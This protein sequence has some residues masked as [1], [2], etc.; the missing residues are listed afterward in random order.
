[1]KKGGKWNGQVNDEVS[2]AFED[3]E[4]FDLDNSDDLNRFINK[5]EEILTANKEKTGHQTGPHKGH[6]GE[7]ALRALSQP[8]NT[9][10]YNSA[11]AY[12]KPEPTG[13]GEDNMVED[14]I[15]NLVDEELSR[16]DNSELSGDDDRDG[17]DAF[18]IKPRRDAE[19]AGYST[20]SAGPFGKAK[21]EGGLMNV[22]ISTTSNKA[23]VANGTQKKYQAYIGSHRSSLDDKASEGSLSSSQGSN[24]SNGGESQM[25]KELFSTT[26]KQINKDRGIAGMISGGGISSG[27]G[28]IDAD[29]QLI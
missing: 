14:E 18:E 26:N 21:T 6:A 29:D 24:A 16:N 8:G 5:Y 13:N 20:Q 23:G 4:E 17:A 10:K 2:A 3:D 22:K 19:H 12:P 27:G 11:S 1:M 25:F 28:L 7:K 15:D 9:H